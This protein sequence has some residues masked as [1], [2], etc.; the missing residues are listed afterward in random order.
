[1]GNLIHYAVL[2]KEPAGPTP[3][4]LKRAFKSFSNL[5]DA[6]AVRVAFSARGILAKH[7]KRDEARA[8][9]LALQ[10]EGVPVAVVAET[11]LPALPEPLTLS[12]IGLWPQSLTVYDPVGRATSVAW[13]RIFLVAAGAAQ[14][15]ELNRTHTHFLRLQLNAPVRPRVEKTPDRRQKIEPESQLVL[16]LIVDRGARRYDIDA[17]QFKFKHVIDRP[18]LTIEEKFIWLV[19]QVCREATRAIRTSGALR[20]AQGEN[21]VPAYF[22]RQVLTDEIVWWM[23]HSAKNSTAAG[24]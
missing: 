11:N 23:W 7:L 22:N 6:D 1:M 15:L 10:D 24:P 3:D 18:G 9:Q 12:R 4:Q 14:Y 21:T 19:R 20:L 2:Q 8:L 16:E 13:N 17:S 5:T